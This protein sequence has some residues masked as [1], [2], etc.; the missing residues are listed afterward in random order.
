MSTI[1]VPIPAEW[2]SQIKQLIALGEE[3][4]TADIARKGI[5]K[6]LDEKAVQMVLSAHEEPT[7]HGDIDALSQKL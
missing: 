6:Y 3:S 1:S 5:R 2:L 4:S 7:L